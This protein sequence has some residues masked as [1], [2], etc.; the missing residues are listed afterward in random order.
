MTGQVRDTTKWK[1]T[2]RDAN[3]AGNTLCMH[4]LTQLFQFP[5]C[6]EILENREW[7]T[8]ERRWQTDSVFYF[9]T[10]IPLSSTSTYPICHCCYDQSIWHKKG[11]FGFLQK[12][13]W[14]HRYTN[15]KQ[16]QR[17]IE[18]PILTYKSA[19]RSLLRGQPTYWDKPD[20][21][22]P[23]FKDVSTT[24]LITIISREIRNC[25]NL[26]PHLT[27]FTSAFIKC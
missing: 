21:Q 1:N 22:H 24:F 25:N 5:W 18:I 20:L 2:D 11:S 17:S 13:H 23:P 8:T 12:C 27:T 16:D 10:E 7:K 6:Y 14:Q 4:L 9:L 3:K 26:K 19:S 15:L